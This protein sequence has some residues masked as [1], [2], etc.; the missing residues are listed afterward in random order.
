MYHQDA[1][2]QFDLIKLILV[3]LNNRRSTTTFIKVK[4]HVGILLNE[5]ADKL[6]K[7]G[8][9]PACITVRVVDRQ[10]WPL[11]SPGATASLLMHK[12]ML[13]KTFRQVHFKAKHE[14]WTRFAGITTWQFMTKHQGKQYYTKAKK[15]LSLANQ[16]LWI[17]SKGNVYPT[18]YH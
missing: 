14:I 11:W 17:L 13:F 16:I 18:Q 15:L 3:E 5:T 1:T 4:S 6:A 2:D 12:V 10:K 8:L 9:D 7:I